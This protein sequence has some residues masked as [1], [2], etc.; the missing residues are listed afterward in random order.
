MLLLL[1]LILRQAP[2]HFQVTVPLRLP[3]L[4]MVHFILSYPTS[5]TLKIYKKLMSRICNERKHTTAAFPSPGW[6]ITLLCNFRS[7]YFHN[8]IMISCFSWLNTILLCT[9]AIFSFV[10]H[11]FM[12]DSSL[13]PLLNYFKWCSNKWICKHSHGR[14][15]ILMCIMA[16]QALIPSSSE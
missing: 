12:G 14:T 8:N 9:H 7:I 4:F 6:K 16:T 1:S 15:S 13:A 10:T 3:S 11:L 2:L 5:T